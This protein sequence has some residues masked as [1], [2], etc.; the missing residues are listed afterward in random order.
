[1]TSN[2]IRLNITRPLERHEI[3]RLIKIAINQREYRFAS[4]LALDWLTEYPGDLNVKYW[5]GLSRSKEG[6]LHLAASILDELLQLDPEYLEAL[7]ARIVVE[8]QIQN[9]T[10]K[11][12]ASLQTSTHSPD[13][14]EF[15]EWLIALS[16]E[17]IGLPKRP[18]E[19]LAFRWG[20]ELHYLQKS[21]SGLRSKETPE[22]L[23]SLE[24]SMH[25]LIAA[26]SDHPLIAITHTRALYQQYLDRNYP[27]QALRQLVEHYLDDFPQCLY[28]NYV[29][30][31]C[32][33]ETS[34]E[35]KA[36]ALLHSLAAK[37]ISAQVAKRVWGTDKSFFTIWPKTLYTNLKIPI[38]A[39]IAAYLGLNQLPG[40]ILSELTESSPLQPQTMQDNPILAT[41]SLAQP[42]LAAKDGQ[43]NEALK[44]GLSPVVDN[45]LE[46]YNQISQRLKQ[47]QLANLDGRQPVYVILTANQPLQAALGTSVQKQIEGALLNLI[48]EVQNHYG[49]QGFIYYVDEGKTL[50][51]AM[52]TNPR[53][54]DK[55][56]DPWQ[57]KHC[58]TDLDHKLA[59]QG[60][61]IGA[62]L[63]VGGNEI[64]PFHRLPN[65]VED[66]DEEILSDNP[67]GSRDENY[68]ALDW[69]LGRIPTPPQD[70]QFILDLLDQITLAHQNKI[71]KS[72]KSKLKYPSIEW[73]FSWISFL[74]A[75][76]N[77]RN[78]LPS[79]FGYTAAAWRFA[80]FAVFQEL[81]NPQTM[82]ISP[83]NSSKIKPAQAAKRRL[84]RHGSAQNKETLIANPMMTSLVRTPNV[85]LPQAKNGYFNLHGL[86]DSAEWFGQSDPTEAGYYDPTQSDHPIALQPGDILLNNTNAFNI[87]L[88]E[89]CFGANITKKQITDSIALSFLSKGC[90][91]FVGSTATAYGSNSTPLIAADFLA[92]AFWKNIRS[93]LPAG[94]ALRQAKLTLAA[95]VG[96][97]QPTL[98]AEDQKTI[99][100]FILLGDPLTQSSYDTS[101]PKVIRH[102][103]TIQSALNTICDRG[104][105]PYQPDELSPK[106]ETAIKKM[107]EKYLPGMEQAQLSVLGNGSE[108][109]GVC[110]NC[111]INCALKHFSLKTQ[112]QHAKAKENDLS[113]RRIVI[114]KKE[115]HWQ[116]YT[117]TQYA[118]MTLDA[119][120]KLVKL[121]ISK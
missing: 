111:A 34:K 56:S 63:I 48:N 49:W 108:C 40:N 15:Q 12:V 78:P 27:V 18:Y 54:C 9:D 72:I 5:Y 30:V 38:P 45:I 117:Y 96:K 83:Q 47:P 88:S 90:R 85:Q 64:I 60:E 32:L 61:M 35:E 116:N 43:G 87:V 91:A 4:Q 73:F 66:G 17:T 120:G 80:S 8:Q 24:L 104:M 75:L 6:H 69:P 82:L 71:S 53:S 99:I 101:A 11:S 76:F 105:R 97:T 2:Q 1:M 62:L 46:T 115:N 41:D 92:Q 52:K 20:E 107:V 29:L 50:P 33:M 14:F 58:L 81:G 39:G 23:Q 37:D 109:H 10:R 98:D 7:K 55:P 93:G 118:R 65:P 36:V 51:A 95:P 57:I 79:S 84:V 77:H 67:Y 110:E 102:T 16:G 121:S 68:L 3:L 70:P 74:T 31:D 13:L 28:L 44:S 86:I 113:E 22:A 89:A 26:K 19:D 21:L 103:K 94:E 119:S 42:S 114:L 59:S 25:D 106:I 100:S 112:N